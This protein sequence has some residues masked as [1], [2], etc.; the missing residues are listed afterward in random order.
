[1]S[2][3]LGGHFSSDGMGDMQLL[4]DLVKPSFCS[5]FFSFSLFSFPLSPLPSPPPFSVLA[6]YFWRS[7]KLE[8]KEADALGKSCEGGKEGNMI[9]KQVCSG[10][11]VLGDPLPE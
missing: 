1:M 2:H 6:G 8:E 4:F 7:E 9:W 11:G 3:Q 5:P 10:A